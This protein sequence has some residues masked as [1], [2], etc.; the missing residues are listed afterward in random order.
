MARIEEELK[1]FNNVVT[2]IGCNI[3]D[4]SSKAVEESANVI[5][6]QY[7]QNRHIR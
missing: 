5:L 2:R 7:Y 6:G 4:V 3:V 1:H